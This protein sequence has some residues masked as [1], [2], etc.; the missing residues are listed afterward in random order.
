MMT[1]PRP[2]Q[3]ILDLQ[4]DLIN[5]SARLVGGPVRVEV[6]GVALVDPS[7][8]PDDLQDA[9]ENASFLGVTWLREPR[10][11]ELSRAAAWGEWFE[12]YLDLRLPALH[13]AANPGAHR[14]ARVIWDASETSALLDGSWK[15]ATD[16]TAAIAGRACIRLTAEADAVADLP[17]LLSRMAANEGPLDLHVVPANP[18]AHQALFESKDTLETAAT[19]TAMNL[20]VRGL[21]HWSCGKPHDNLLA[22]NIQHAF[23]R[24]LFK[25]RPGV[26]PFPFTMLAMAEDETLRLCPNPEGPV[27]RR[28]ADDEIWNGEA[29]VALRK[30]FFDSA[31]A[32]PCKKCVLYPRVLRSLHD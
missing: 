15:G 10:E 26:C 6:P 30:G 25:D 19:S 3:D 21:G 11:E 31:L 22:W 14:T 32:A 13:S 7:D 23:L 8:A 9:L 4:R 20:S 28:D 2:I 1:A 12:V 5:S 16:T 27:V 29:S 17:D 18:A 24:T